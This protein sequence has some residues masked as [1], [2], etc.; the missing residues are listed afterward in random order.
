MR[1]EL[2]NFQCH[3]HYL[4]ELPETGLVLIQG[5]NGHGKTTILRAIYW[6]L[7]GT[8]TH[9]EP[10]YLKNAR[11]CVKLEF[12]NLKIQRSKKPIKLQVNYMGGVFLNDEAQKLIISLFGSSDVWLACC[13]LQQGKTNE[14]I[15][16]KG[17][18]RISLLNKLS[19]SDQDPDKDIATLDT[20][21]KNYG[22]KFESEQAAYMARLANLTEQIYQFGLVCDNLTREYEQLPTLDETLSVESLTQEHLLIKTRLA[23]AHKTVQQFQLELEGGKRQNNN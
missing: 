14:L 19:F 12:A 16:S 17:V 3:R 8:L 2:E 21:I 22:N 4:V 11:T 1:L 15:D 13:Y 23:Q 9:V 6:A 20:L 7:Y 5:I 10:M 18:E